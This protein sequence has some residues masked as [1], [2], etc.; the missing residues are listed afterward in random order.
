MESKYLEQTLRM[1]EMNLNLGIIF[2]TFSLDV[3]HLD[4]V[5][6]KLIETLAVITTDCSKEVVLVVFSLCVAM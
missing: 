3:A 1:L 5:L 4:L 6:V 2:E